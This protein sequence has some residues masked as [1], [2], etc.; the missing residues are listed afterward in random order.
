MTFTCLIF[1]TNDA[2]GPKKVFPVKSLRRVS[3]GPTQL[4]RTADF[5]M[6]APPGNVT[7]PKKVSKFGRFCKLTSE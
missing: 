5:A 4:D 2:I 6:R 7:T 1:R 3:R